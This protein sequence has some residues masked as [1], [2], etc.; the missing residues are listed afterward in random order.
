MASIQF[1]IVEY[2]LDYI[3]TFIILQITNNAATTSKTLHNTNDWVHFLHFTV[4]MDS[5]R[6]ADCYINL[7]RSPLGQSYWAMQPCM[8]QS[9][10]VFSELCNYTN[11]SYI[12]M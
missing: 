7:D 6:F 1:D 12:F 5:I 11:F 3:S 2:L 8:I 9:P 10:V 4:C